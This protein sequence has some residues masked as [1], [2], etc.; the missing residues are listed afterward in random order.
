[1]NKSVRNYYQH[2]V[3]SGTPPDDIEVPDSP[4]AKL[5]TPTGQCIVKKRY[6]ERL[7]LHSDMEV[8]FI[9]NGRRA[10]KLVIMPENPEES[11]EPIAVVP[12]AEIESVES[13]VPYDTIEEYAVGG[14]PDFWHTELS[15]T[16]TH[17]EDTKIEV[18]PQERLYEELEKIAEEDAAYGSVEQV[19]LA[20]CRRLVE[21]RENYGEAT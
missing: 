17:R 1:M 11:Q 2:L 3:E 19:A 18:K 13:G 20:A 14:E 5:Q 9:E 7:M 12:A 4:P 16:L 8:S 6:A 15:F 21:E 10:E